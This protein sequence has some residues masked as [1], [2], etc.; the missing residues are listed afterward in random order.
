MAILALFIGCSPHPTA[1]IVT[2]SHHVVWRDCGKQL[3]CARVFVPLDWSNRNGAQIRL[4]VIRR[5]ASQPRRRIGAIFFNPGGPG[6]S[7]VD[8][9]K[10]TGADLDNLG[11]GRF[12]IV[13]WDPRGGGASTHVRCFSDEGSLSSFWDHLGVPTTKAASPAYL[14]K[15]VG[16]ARRCGEGSGP[17]LRHISTADTARD[18]D[19]LR[20]LLGE[21]RLTYLGWSYGSFVGSVYANMFPN[22]VR[23]MALD[24]IIDPVTYT[25][26]REAF[27]ANDT[28]DADL[29][30]GKFESLCQSAGP[31]RCVLAGRGPVPARVKR[32]LTRLRRAPIRAPFAQGG[33]L[34][35]GDAL[36]A[37]FL[38]LRSPEGW[39][40]FAKDLRAAE[41]GD[42]SALE[43]VALTLRSPTGYALLEPSVAIGCADAPAL[44]PPR[45]WPQVID[46][47]THVSFIYGPLLGWWLWAPCASWPVAGAN[48]YTGPWSAKTK[49]PILIIGT[50]F[51]PNT[52]FAN[53][54]RLEHILARA[55]L[56]THDGYGHTST[57]DPSTC[58]EREE[59]RYFVSLIVP[60]RGAVCRSDRL[61]FDPNFGKPFSGGSNAGTL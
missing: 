58:V 9:V 42:G 30:F 61:P 52:P 34:S 47:L 20:G 3:E 11:G 15:T 40:R 43:T 7:G 23:A 19:Y 17:L 51:D 50:R 8:T 27:L 12:D 35:Y 33:K 1:R 48:R 59:R 55:V 45:A 2:V 28:V 18:L 10:A 6:V 32:L 13:S 14:S 41:T 37:F 25:T 24:G 53:A 60:A 54:Q 56:L 49:V 16:F 21:R 46:R 29:V 38:L 4:A 31:S 5:V 36:A 22:R 57:V 26:G 44:Q 39:P